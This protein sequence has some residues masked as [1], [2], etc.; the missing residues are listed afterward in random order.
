MRPAVSAVRVVRSFVAILSASPE[1]AHDVRLR[2]QS[3]PDWDPI[4]FTSDDKKSELAFKDAQVT[5]A[6]ECSPTGQRLIL[7]V[8]DDAEW[9]ETQGKSCM[10]NAACVDWDP[11]DGK[12]RVL[13]SIV[14]LPPIFVYRQHGTIAVASELRL[15]RAVTGLQDSINPQAA[16]E[17]FTVGYPLGYRTLFKDISLMPG[18]HSL[19]VDTRAQTDLAPSVEVLKPRPVEDWSTYIDLQA[20]AFRQA[21]GKL[22]LTDSVFSLTGGFDTRTILA[23]L[24]ETGIKLPAC[25]LSGG[26]TLCLDA[27]LAGMLSIAYGLPHIVVTLDD[28]FLKDLPTYILEA[29]KLSGGLASVEQAHE[30]YFYR[31]LKRLGSRRLSGYLGNQIG[32]A[33]VEGISIRRADTQVLNDAIRAVAGTELNDHWLVSATAPSEDTLFQLLIQREVPFSSVGNYSIGHHFMIQQSPYASR[34]LIEISS[35]APLRKRRNPPFVS[36]HAR[37]HDLRHRFLGQPRSRSF[38]RRVIEEAGGVAAEC[39]INWGW[40]VRGVPSLRGFG[41]GLVAFADAALSRPRPTLRFGRQV[42]RAMGFDGMHEITQYPTWFDTV[43]RE[44][45]NDILRSRLVKDSELFNTKAVIRMLDE[46]YH[47]D[48]SYYSSLVATLDLALAQQ[49]FFERP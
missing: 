23:V 41:C 28:A 20:E 1:K 11:K 35:R 5:P 27:R 8:G 21:V 26:R 2:L 46:H 33:G 9:D 49:L 6:H 24:S 15:L 40:R 13:S 32:R 19:R 14:G 34:K 22:R 30:V 18:G 47:G 16:V 31:Q 43:L 42:L 4:H 10:A 38:Q 45:V 39:P 7:V 17:L 25:T 36:G 29:S 37:F 44:F 48:R 3:L 12:L